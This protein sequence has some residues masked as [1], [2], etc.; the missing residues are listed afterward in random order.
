MDWLIFAGPLRQN[1]QVTKTMPRP[2][3]ADEQLNSH[4][5][6]TDVFVPIGEVT[7]RR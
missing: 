1:S 7:I 2:D 5:N 3:N 4:A 6:S